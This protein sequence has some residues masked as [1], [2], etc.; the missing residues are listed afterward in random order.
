MNELRVAF[1]GHLI[2]LGFVVWF[3]FPFVLLEH[4]RKK[5]LRKEV[6]EAYKRLKS[7][8][9]KCLSMSGYSEVNLGKL[10][11]LSMGRRPVGESSN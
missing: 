3:F 4:L 11:A 2:S 8:V 7:T 1:G 9:D 10:F 5:Q 6:T